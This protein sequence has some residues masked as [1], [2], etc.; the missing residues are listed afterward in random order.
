[1]E[2]KPLYYAGE[3]LRR[4]DRP[5]WGI[6]QVLENSDDPLIETFFEYHGRSQ[7]DIRKADTVSVETGEERHPI[8]DLL[9]VED[10]NWKGVHHSIYVVLL[11]EAVLENWRFRQANRH[12]TGGK[13]CLYVGMTGLKPERR[14]R[15]HKRGHKANY[16]VRNYGVRL[17]SELYQ[18]FNPMP[19]KLAQV[20][21]VE[22]A[23]KLRSQG[24][25]V[26]Q[27]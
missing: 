12:Y 4:L 15:N 8:L 26:W 9:L 18:N 14:F 2:A 22:V 23:E 27:H 16:Y 25:A 21:E 7:I 19:Y 1:M 10:L 6:G 11:D 5:E 13:P 24:F 3:R 20:V 17:V